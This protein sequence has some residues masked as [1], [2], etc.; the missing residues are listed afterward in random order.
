MSSITCASFGKTRE[1]DPVD[2]YTLCNNRG[3]ETRIMT[4]GGAVVSLTAPDRTGKYDD[5]VLGHDNFEDYLKCSHYFGALIGRCANRIGGAQFVL[6]DKTYKLA[7]NDGPHCLHGGV[8]GFDKVV[9]KAK[10]AETAKGSVLGL[11]Y[12][13]KDGE[14]GFPGNLSVEAI[15]TLTDNNELQLIFTATTD[16]PTI[17][18]LTHHPYFNLAAKGNVLD[19]ELHINASR[20]T[21]ADS[22]LVS[23]GELKSVDGTPFD[24]R[25]PV[26]IGA[27]IDH[28]DMQLKFGKGYDHNWVIDKPLHELGLVARVHE[29][30]TGRVME[31]LS[32]KPGAQFYT[33]NH[34]NGFVGKGGRAYRSRDAFCIEPGHYLDAPNKPHF[35]TTV[36]MPGQTYH[37]TIIYRFLAD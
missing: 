28:G 8:K 14:E 25:K 30:T 31:V 12:L 23:T 15:Y 18:N 9:W 6:G 11:T 20:F 5:V 37:N 1:G 26:K 3:M 4:Y 10:T 2:I 17:C 35:P 33:G 24:F 22:T 16:A 21:P 36:L 34:L 29:P 13:S 19:H 27:R 7:K 32:T